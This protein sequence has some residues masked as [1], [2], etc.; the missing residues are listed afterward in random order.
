MLQMSHQRPRRR[1]GACVL[2]CAV[3][4]ACA[5]YNAKKKCGSGGCPGDSQIT[6]AVQAQLDQHPELGPPN[7][8][9][10]QTLDGVVYLSGQVATDLQRSIAESAARAAPGVTKVVDN[11]SWNRY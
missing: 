11:I 2:L 5:A 1:L 7:R 10:V 4:S 8:V 3:L 6:A 9:Y